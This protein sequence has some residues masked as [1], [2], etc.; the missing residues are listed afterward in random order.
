M[1]YPKG[2]EPSALRVG[3]SRSIQ[4]S[5]GYTS[6]PINSI[7]ESGKE[8]KRLCSGF[9]KN[10]GAASGEEKRGVRYAGKLRKRRRNTLRKDVVYDW[11]EKLLKLMKNQLTN[12]LESYII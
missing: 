4:L 12:D 2:F 9:R 11:L 5:Y 10:V 3:V 6:R 1:A 8:C 7:H